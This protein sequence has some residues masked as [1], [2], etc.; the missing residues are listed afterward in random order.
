M[1]TEVEAGPVR[2][3]VS[4]T[5]PTAQVKV[6]SPRAVV[7][8]RLVTAIVEAKRLRVQVQTNP[9]GPP[10]PAGV[11]GSTAPR[12]FSATCTA[13]EA[14]DDL[15][16]IIGAT[17]LVLD[18]R[19]VDVDDPSTL[20]V[21]GII[22]DKPTATTANVQ[23]AGE[24][25]LSGLTP[26]AHYFA[27]TDSKLTDTPPGSPGSGKRGIQI[28]GYALTGTAFLIQPQRPTLVIP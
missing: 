11:D 12:I 15:V 6:T 4:P 18:V 10:G 22:L 2:V 19:K 23:V 20:P 26:G 8:T 16:Y 24:V 9:Q 1:T 13:A 25:T 21:R 7:L 27:G 28:V 17:G 5:Q 3:I 14:A